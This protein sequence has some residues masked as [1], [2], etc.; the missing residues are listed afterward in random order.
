MERDRQEPILLEMY[1]EVTRMKQ[2]FRHVEGIPIPLPVPPT[3]TGIS[4]AIGWEIV[5]FK[6]VPWGDPLLKY[7]FVPF[8][9]ASFISYFEPD[10]INPF[11]WLYAH[12][13]KQIR[14]IRRIGNRAVPR[15]GYRKEYRQQTIIRSERRR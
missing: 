3:L 8:V 4:V 12:I 6:W 10:N 15:I 2:V 5:M 9:L 7:L 13:R 1:T 11:Q 14:P